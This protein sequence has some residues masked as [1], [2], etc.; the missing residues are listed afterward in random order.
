MELAPAVIARHLRSSTVAIAWR[1]E[2]RKTRREPHRGQE[3]PFVGLLVRAVATYACM[4][5]APASIGPTR[6][7]NA[8]PLIPFRRALPR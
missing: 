6:K 4:S 5:T 3:E 1:L 7:G 8:R 2:R